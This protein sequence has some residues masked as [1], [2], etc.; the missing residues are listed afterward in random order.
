MIHLRRL[1]INQYRTV[2]PTELFFG[3]GHNF[4]L[5]KNGSGKTTLLNLIVQLLRGDLRGFLDRR[6]ALDVEME[7][8]GTVSGSSPS[9]DG[10]PL[11]FSTEVED[12][13][14][15]RIAPAA[16]EAPDVVRPGVAAT[17]ARA[18]LLVS[19]DLVRRV[20][21][22]ERGEAVWGELPRELHGRFEGSVEDGAQVSLGAERI[23]IPPNALDASSQAQFLG[24]VM[25]QI[26][27]CIPRTSDP[28]LA[29]FLVQVLFTGL[30]IQDGHLGRFDEALG[31]YHAIL[32][33]ETPE[34]DPSWPNAPTFTWRK[35]G[36][37]SHHAVPGPISKAIGEDMRGQPEL[38]TFD[39]S[40]VEPMQQL[41]TDLGA[42][43]IVAHAN[44]DSGTRDSVTFSGFN[45]DFYWTDGVFHS[46]KG[47][48]FGQ[49]RLLAFLWYA[50]T[51][52][53]SPAITDELTNG[54]HVDWVH[55]CIE[56]IGDRQAFHAVQNPLLVDR[57]GPA[58]TPEQL[59]QSFVFCST[60][61]A[62]GER[63]WTWRNPTADE[64]KMLDTALS[65]E[66]Q[67]LSE[68]LMNRGLW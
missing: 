40:K 25:A 31:Y 1:K 47:L 35:G 46:T 65:Y 57:A 19:A 67:L 58:E 55:R 7:L 62:G 10:A 27:R 9:A 14:R 11:A 42:E 37:R 17:E 68:I 63:R 38:R 48:S 26:A 41:A 28:A 34:H 53:Q 52:G 56:A 2:E 32:N 6:E 18:R 44:A 22:D 30:R 29:N 39:L 4:V 23:D 20:R 64:A 59:A 45:F 54:L 49:K 3:E 5:G 24:S 16:D 36:S 21:L 15:L 8:G 61:F 43:R 66:I 50:A 13:F 51:L 60:S 12:V 33:G